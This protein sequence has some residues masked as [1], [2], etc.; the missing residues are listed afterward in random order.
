MN[1]D[2]LKG[3]AYEDIK[4]RL[5]SNRIKQGERIR[6]D[7]IAQELE[8]SR[9]PVREAINQLVA[10]NF[11]VS[12]PRRGLFAA[13][14]TGSQVLKML[15]VRVALERLSAE[16]CC[17]RITD[18]QFRTLK[19]IFRNYETQLRRGNYIAANRLDRGMH[20][21]IAGVSQNEKLCHYIRD[22]QDF[23][24]Y[25]RGRNVNWTDKLA[26]GAIGHHRNLIEAIGQR[27]CAKA[28]E[29]MERD[30]RAMRDLIGED[31]GGETNGE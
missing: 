29:M 17:R 1:R 19:E 30:I 4:E 26:G 16:E 12:I 15:D 9:T 22:L 10:E 14:I 28:A 7:L 18:G 25:A 8:M 11:V 13:E 2:G 27:D 6:E 5:V 24:A 23:F 31:T 3:I 20:E 21:F